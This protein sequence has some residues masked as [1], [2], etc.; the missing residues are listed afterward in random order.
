MPGP[1]LLNHHSYPIEHAMMKTYGTLSI[2]V[3][4]LLLA[5]G[6]LYKGIIT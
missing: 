3:I 2:P 1:P 4:I 5:F 6:Y